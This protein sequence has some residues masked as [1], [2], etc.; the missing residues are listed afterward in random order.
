[1]STPFS[2]DSSAFDGDRKP[3]LADRLR[4]A[5]DRLLSSPRFHHWASAFPLTRWKARREARALFD[6]CGGFVYSQILLACVRVDLFRLL[7]G[8]PLAAP[9]IATRIGMSDEAATRLLDA[10]VAL[11]LVVRRSGGRYGLGMLGTAMVANPGIAAMV[12]H[13]GRIYRDFE[14][15]LALLRGLSQRTA[16]SQYWPYAGNEQA[17]ALEG[18]RIRD[19]TALMA[20]SQPMVASEVLD[21]YP[22]AM[23]RCLLDIGGGDGSFLAA[24]AQRAP[25]LKL[26]LFDLPAV[27]ERARMRFDAAGLAARATA[28]GGSFQSG[29]LPTGADLVSLVR[30]LHDHDDEDVMALLRA[31]HRALPDDGVLLIAE[32]MSGVRGAEPVGDAYFGFYL[33]AMG[34]GRPRSEARLTEMLRAAGF[35]QIGL[36]PTRIPLQTCVLVARPKHLQT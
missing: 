1:M 8:G 23:H 13:H 15:P 28:F 32:Q 3:G 21:A 33:M 7:A 2:M 24:A 22:V 30:V 10:A 11:R 6:L 12:E 31:V 25:D 4:D 5:A 29:E 14:D 19:Y 34:R 26:Q 16:L 36:I 35:C 20:A 27:A 17:S 9:R 18:E